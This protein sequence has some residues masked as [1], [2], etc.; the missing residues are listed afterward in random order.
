[1]KSLRSNFLVYFI[2][3][4]QSLLVFYYK[5]YK[6]MI[7]A[8]G[9]IF[10]NNNYDNNCLFCKYQLKKTILILIVIIY[11]QILIKKKT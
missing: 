5:N 4:S 8:F 6:L 10:D 2:H 9:N 3:F 7:M 11:M 1:M